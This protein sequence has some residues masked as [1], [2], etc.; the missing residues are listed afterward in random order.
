MYASVTPLVPSLVQIGSVVFLRLPMHFTMSLFSTVWKGSDSSFEPLWIPIHMKLTQWSRRRSFFKSCQ[1]M[2][3]HY[4]TIINTSW[5]WV[6]LF[7]YTN[8]NLFVLGLVEIGPVVLQ[9][10]IFT[11]SA[12][13][14]TLNLAI[15]S[16]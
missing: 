7:I 16:P 12:C 13:I 1:L 4:A 2:Y 5:K 11:A 3:Y 10:K 6:W 8:L 15:N 14:F 9:K